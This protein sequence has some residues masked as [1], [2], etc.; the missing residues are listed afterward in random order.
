MQVRHRLYI[1]QSSLQSRDKTHFMR[2]S[3]LYIIQ[4]RKRLGSWLGLGLRSP[5]G[6]SFPEGKYRCLGIPEVSLSDVN[7]DDGSDPIGGSISPGKIAVAV[8]GVLGTVLHEEVEEVLGL[9]TSVPVE[10]HM[11]SSSDPL[12]MRGFVE[13][14]L[15]FFGVG[16]S[17]E[18][19]DGV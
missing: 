12:V 11:E 19:L 3:I 13:K 14:D 8:S 16:G 18:F 17:S 2:F 4:S 15:E 6:R 9:V 1:L 10:S 5:R 7:R